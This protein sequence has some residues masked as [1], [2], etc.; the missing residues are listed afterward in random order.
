MQLL[1]QR[2][3]MMFALL[4]LFALALAGCSLTV[5]SEEEIEQAWLTSAHANVESRSF[6]RWNDNDPAE[7]PE[8]CAG[9]HSTPGYLDFL[10][11]DGSTP[12]QVDHPA[13]IGTTIECEACH[14]DAAERKQVSTMPSGME[15]SAP[16]G[17]AACMDCHQGRASGLDIAE[18]T[19]D[20]PLDEVNRELQLPNVHNNAAAPIF[21]GSES[22]GGY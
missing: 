12:G 14:N 10:G 19:Q 15:V 6:T 22:L 4:T 3:I 16:S 18:A 13:P 5:A 8:N 11:Q 1:Q 9:C 2:T 20:M 17:Q 21:L 7:I